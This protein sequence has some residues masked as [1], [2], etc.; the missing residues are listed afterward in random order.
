M[1]RTK[2]KAAKRALKRHPNKNVQSLADK[3]RPGYVFN[4]YGF[5]EPIRPLKNEALF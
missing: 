5:E 4:E 3:P 1:N 2:R